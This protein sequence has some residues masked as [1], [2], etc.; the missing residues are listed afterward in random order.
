MLPILTRE[1]ERSGFD[2]GNASLNLYIKELAS[3]DMKRGQAK[4]YVYAVDIQVLGY[5]TIAP[6]S[7]SPGEMPAKLAKKYDPRKM[8]SCWLI[9]KLARDLSVKGRGIGEMLLMDALFRIKRL[10][11][12]GG[13]YCVIVDSKDDHASAFY[14]S[15]GFEILDETKNERRFFLPISEIPDPPED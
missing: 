2:C 4:V 15:F 11:S 6:F 3:S 1:H 7:F 8:V 14:R 5:Y 12:E 13:G 9:G 10:A